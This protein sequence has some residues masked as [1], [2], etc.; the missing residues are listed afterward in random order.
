MLTYLQ[1]KAILE[2]SFLPLECRCSLG[3][4]GSMTLMFLR[5]FSDVVELVVS[6]VTAEHWN[7]VRHLAALVLELREELT[8]CHEFNQ[9]R[10]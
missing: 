10:G 8:L 1:A 9:R 7:S 4:D 2:G 3:Y 6:G 5:P